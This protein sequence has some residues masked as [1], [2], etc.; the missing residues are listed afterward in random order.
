MSCGNVLTAFLP[1]LYMTKRRAHSWLQGSDP[2]LL[3]CQEMKMGWSRLKELSDD[4]SNDSS[5][6]KGNGPSTRV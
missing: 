6:E 3:A 4:E 5:Q 1:A 2:F